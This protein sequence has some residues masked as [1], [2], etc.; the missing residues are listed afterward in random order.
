MGARGRIRCRRGV[1]AAHRRSKVIT[2]HW[3]GANAFHGWHI[4]SL[5]TFWEIAVG[6][7][8]LKKI[9]EGLD[10]APWLLTAERLPDPWDSATLFGREAVLEIEVGSGK[11]LFVETAAREHPERNF[12]GIEIAFKY[13]RYCAARLARTEAGF[14][15]ILHGDAQ[16]VFADLLPDNALRAVH[17]YFPDP[18]WKRRHRDRRVMNERFV[19]N[20]ERTLQPGGKLHFWTDVQE[21]FDTTLEL[22]EA[23]T[24]L[25]GPAEVLPKAADHDLDYRT[26]FERRMIMH[27]EAV[28]RS[29]FVCK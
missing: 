19:K 23:A 20:V 12:L 11:G 26:H 15:K 1:D 27:A 24:M 10:L 28:Y 21:Y 2:A 16:P 4:Q 18:W 25:E 8:P 7:R 17:V 13:A 29:E 14:A 9:H 3:I 6:R 22:V 5:D